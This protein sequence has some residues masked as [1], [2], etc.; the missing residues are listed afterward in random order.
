VGGK[1]ETG[2]IKKKEENTEGSNAKKKRRKLYLSMQL[3]GITN[4]PGR[5]NFKIHFKNN[6]AQRMQNKIRKF[7]LCAISHTIPNLISLQIK[8]TCG[9]FKNAISKKYKM[10]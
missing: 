6:H 1:I 5:S 10:H 4:I 7:V 2:A 9:V 8:L 3:Y